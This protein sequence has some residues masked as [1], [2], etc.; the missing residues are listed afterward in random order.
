MKVIFK[1][2]MA[3]GFCCVL[4]FIHQAEAL[5]PQNS[6][7]VKST[8]DEVT[9]TAVQDDLSTTGNQN[10]LPDV[11]GTKIYSGKKTSLVDF[12]KIPKVN[13]NNYRQALAKVPG[14]ILSEESTPLFSLGY[15]GLNPDRTQFM[16]VLKD[17]IPIHADM[18]GYPEAYYTPP[19]DSVQKIELIRGGAGLMYGP[20]PG[21]AL[22]FVTPMPAEDTPLRLHSSNSFG[23]H[24]TFSTYSALTGKMGIVGYHGYFHER[25]SSGFR[26]SNSDYEVLSSSVKLTVDPTEDSKVTMTFD[27]YNEE[28]GEPGG[29]TR[30]QFDLDETLTTRQSDRFHLERY[31]GSVKYENKLDETTQFEILVYGG[32]Y[33]RWSRRQNGGGFGTIPTASTNSISEHDFYNLG[34]EE[35]LRHD[36]EFWN[37]EHTVSFGTHTFLSHSPI[38]GQTGSNPFADSGIMDTVT[39]RDTWAFSPF[40]ENLFRWGRF[41]VTPGVRL[42]NIWQRVNEKFRRTGRLPDKHKTYDFAPLFG[43]GVTFEI[44]KGIDAYGNISQSYRPKLFSQTIPTGATQVI[45]EDLEEGKGVQYDFGFRGKRYPFWNWD[46]GYFLMS[47]TN[48]I[49]TSGNTVTN[50][51]RAHYQGLEMF[52]EFDWV[53]AWDY[54]KNTKH[55]EKYGNLASF[56][57]MTLLDAEYSA[58]PFKDRAPAYAPQYNVKTGLNYRWRDRVKLSLIGTFLGDH[59]GDDASTSTMVVPSYKVWDLTTEIQLL[60]NVKNAFDMSVFGGLNNIFNE[61]YYARVT[62]GGIDPADGRNIYGG[63]KVQLG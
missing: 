22:N 59:F 20:Q 23:S 52:Q 21:G 17:G 62:S 28:H 25:Q 3:A 29:L 63:L 7:V 31:Y 30:A 45:N 37:G 58:G 48:Q 12:N 10:F 14:L 53:G 16:Q 61:K 49:G 38:T 43:V 42:E 34:F 9:V 11:Q 33:R 8:M 50:G 35:R 47:F 1:S 5:S 4:G 39:V 18:F 36:Y 57:T 55:A 24:D 13:N 26:N 56:F 46:V 41:T 60:K 40:F 54:F 27:Q 51:G 15:R 19:F 32:H 2:V 44:M 6:A